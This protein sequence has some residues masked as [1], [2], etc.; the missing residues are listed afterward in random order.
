MKE[1]KEEID[2]EARIIQKLGLN[3]GHKNIIL[4]LKHGW[5]D[6]D[7]YYFDMELCIFN[8][9]DYIMSDIKIIYGIARYIDPRS[10]ED[11]FGCLSLWGIIK[12]I[13]SGLEFIHSHGELHR[14][15]KPKNGISFHI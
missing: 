5:L 8:L 3:G 11:D 9:E 2:N 13:T 7:H 6:D 4:A 14:D 1:I 10:A 12:Q 15:L